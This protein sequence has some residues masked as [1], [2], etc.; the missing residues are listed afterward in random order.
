MGLPKV[1]VSDL[2]EGM[3][4]QEDLLAPNGRFI[5]PKG[6]VIRESYIKTFKAWGVV[7]ASVAEWPVAEEPPVPEGLAPFID[8]ARALTDMFFPREG[9]DEMPM[10]EIHRCGV[11]AMAKS[12]SEGEE[13]PL[14]VGCIPV[15]P[16]SVGVR[17]KVTPHE[18]VA[19]NAFVTLP[20]IYYRIDEVIKAPNSSVEQIARVVGK[21]PSLSAKLLKLV[22]SSFYGLPSRVDS[23]ARAVTLVGTKELLNLAIGVSLL[24]AFKGLDPGYV[25]VR[26]FWTHSVAC[27]V[28]ARILAAKMGIREEER[29]FLAGLMHDIGRLILYVKVPF[30][31]GEVIRLSSQ[32][33]DIYETE[34]DV[35]GFDHGHLGYYALRE[36]KI[37]SSIGELVRF[38]HR[39]SSA[40]TPEELVVHVADVFA[41]AGRFGTSGSFMVPRLSPYHWDQLG[42]SVNVIEPVF[43]QGQ[44]Q[45][46]EITGMFFS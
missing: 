33:Q 16:S 4:L 9:R 18:L 37:P 25:S 46:R 34:Q 43:V 11:L 32:G 12:L 13:V 31:M 24:S 38:H 7:E 35:L 36:W 44:R 21:D 17:R 41:M 1:R 8:R 6:A 10:R 45:I 26:S 39:P 30:S 42:L 23:V 22:N 5:L 29:F 3:V 40:R 20:D 15:S 14:E 19:A 28:F 2:R 27:G